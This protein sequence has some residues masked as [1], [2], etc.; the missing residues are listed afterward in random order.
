MYTASNTQA[1]FMYPAA[2][3]RDSLGTLKM[4]DSKKDWHRETWLRKSRSLVNR[5]AKQDPE[6]GKEVGSV[7][8][9]GN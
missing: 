2:P 3:H 9:T 4:N 7:M 6:V 8:E 1:R 5:Q